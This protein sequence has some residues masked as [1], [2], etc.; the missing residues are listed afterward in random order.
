MSETMDGPR[1]DPQQFREVVRNPKAHASILGQYRI[2][3]YAG[4]VALDRLLG[5]V[6]PDARLRRAMEIHR[7]DEAR[8][9]AVFT[10]WMRRLG[11][12]PP[13]LPTDVEAYFSTSEEEH[14][15]QRA[16]IDALPPDIR[17]IVVF[18]GI[19]AVERLAWNQFGIHLACLDRRDDRELL[20]SVIAEEK[21]HLNYVEAELERQQKGEHGQIV[22]AAL[23][24][25][26]ARFQR[27]DEMRR[28]E[29]RQNVE[30]ILGGT[31]S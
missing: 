14:R 11:V 10:D 16:A 5:D 1:F 18:A 13:V 21:F 23:D 29:T 2:G 22:A 19:N 20:E 12:E 27:F 3:E 8:H 9:T 25:A 7:R 17:R 15:T 6:A 28:N 24:E 26:R 30:R 4:V 31:A